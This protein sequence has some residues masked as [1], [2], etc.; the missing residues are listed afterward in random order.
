[1]SKQWLQ[2]WLALGVLGAPA[3]APAQ[4]IVADVAVDAGPVERGLLGVNLWGTTLAQERYLDEIGADR[5]YRLKIPTTCVAPAPAGSRWSFTNVPILDDPQDMQRLAALARRIRA[6]GG[7]LLVQSFGVPC[8]LSS[9]PCGGCPQSCD[10]SLKPVWMKFPPKP[11]TDAATYAAIHGEI[12]ARL[13]DAGVAPDLFEWNAEANIGTNWVDGSLLACLRETDPAAY[14]GMGCAQTA[15]GQSCSAVPDATDAQIITRYAETLRDVE[16]AVHGVLPA[17]SVG[18]AGLYTVG[19]SAPKGAQGVQAKWAGGLV[20]AA[21][22]GPI[23]LGFWNWHTY[24][25]DPARVGS[26]GAQM[27]SVLAGSSLAGLDGVLTEWGF[28]HP[29]PELVNT[30]YASA[31]LV[32][33]FQS[34]V[35]ARAARAATWFNLQTGFDA[36]LSGKPLSGGDGYDASWGL[37]F[38]AK[39]NQAPRPIYNALRLLALLD[40]RHH[41]VRG[42]SEPAWA[43]ASSDGE[44]A[45]LVAAH[46]EKTLSLPGFSGSLPVTLGFDGLEARDWRVSLYRVDGNAS[47]GV[48]EVCFGAAGGPPCYSGDGGSPELEAP[49]VRVFP[50][51]GSIRWDLVVPSYAV[52]ALVVEPESGGAGGAGGAG[53]GAAATSSAAS[54]AEGSGEPSPGHAAHCHVTGGSA[55]GGAPWLAAFGLALAT[56]ARRRRIAIALGSWRLELGRATCRAR[57]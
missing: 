3:T 16:R 53:G 14:Q 42:A 12:V 32:A 27:M 11:G 18:G 55:R 31:Y 29:H 57:G 5:V 50:A 25:Y 38:A 24:S 48:S 54:A 43:V 33:G 9:Y 21:A 1:M 7:K 44:R 13:V 36:N 22:Q 41:P 4:E 20:Q 45:V 51:A 28:T 35:A 39:K 56:A 8:W 23:D 34:A 47:N 19:P 40:G 46:F 49:E 37:F 10:A 6:A 52:A 26:D 30:H 15:Q 17:L 2:V